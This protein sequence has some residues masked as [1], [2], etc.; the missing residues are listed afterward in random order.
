MKPKRTFYPLPTHTKKEE[1]LTYDIISERTVRKTERI[2]TPY[3]VV[4]LVK[5][6]NRMKQECF[7]VITLNSMHK[8]MRVSLATIGLVN[9]ALIHSREVFNRA[10]ADMATAIIVCHNHPSGD[11]NPSEEDK[12][13]TKYLC[14]AGSI[15][16]IPVLD[17]IIIARNSHYSFKA[18]G[19][20]NENNEYTG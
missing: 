4:R 1:R 19:F 10:I 12:D 7:V 16:G 14:Q 9:K 6:Y 17:H 18:D 3:D 11:S 20:I 13:V 8:P 15:V 5:R 2:T